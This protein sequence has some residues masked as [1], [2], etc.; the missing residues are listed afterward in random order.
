MSTNS[1][2]VSIR[3][4]HRRAT[5]LEQGLSDYMAQNGET[6]DWLANRNT[7]GEIRQRLEQLLPADM[8][9]RFPPPELHALGQLLRDRRNAAGFSRTRLAR[10]A[11]LSDATIKFIETGRHPPSRASLARLWAVPDLHLGPAEWP[12]QAG[13][14]PAAAAAAP[15]SDLLGFFDRGIER[16]IAA[17]AYGSDFAK[18]RREHIGDPLPLAETVFDRQANRA[19]PT[20]LTERAD[21]LA[22]AYAL[23]CARGA[24]SAS[25]YLKTVAEHVRKFNQELSL[26]IYQIGAWLHLRPTAAVDFSRRAPAVRHWPIAGIYGY[27]HGGGEPRK[28]LASAA[29]LGDRADFSAGVAAL[30]CFWAAKR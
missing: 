9:H 5:A 27:L 16:L 2:L 18:Q 20:E 1:R 11:K 6:V 4:L 7:A 12:R 25:D 15:I 17:M 21:F 24:K 28:S 3:E 26:E 19:I 13:N 29:V 30:L 14:M 8:G 23:A 22:V 10:R